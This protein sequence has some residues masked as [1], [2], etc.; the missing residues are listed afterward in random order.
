[1]AF[2]QSSEEADVPNGLQRDKASWTFGDKSS[3]IWDS[4]TCTPSLRKQ[5]WQ[6]RQDLR[7]LINSVHYSK[8]STHLHFILLLCQ[9]QMWHFVWHFVTTNLGWD[10]GRPAGQG[11]LRAE[12]APCQRGQSQAAHVSVLLE[13]FVSF[14]IP[15]DSLWDFFLYLF[16]QQRKLLGSSAQISSGVC[17]CGSQEQVPEE[18]SGRF[19]RFP[20]YAGVGSRGRFRK[21]PERQVPEG[22]G[23]FRR[24]LVYAGV[25]SER[26]V[27]EGLGRFRKVPE[28]SGVCW[29]R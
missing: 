11:Q 26:W 14:W 16:P 24:V 15:M 5:E 28:S 22:S 2:V 12:W 25:G 27:P 4:S 18:G 10:V 23:R 20:A 3:G 6:H 9:R 19:R 13:F 1:M 29:C 7:P 8:N 21:V 17:R